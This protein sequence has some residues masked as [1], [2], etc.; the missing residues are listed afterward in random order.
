VGH[1]FYLHLSCGSETHRGDD[2]REIRHLVVVRVHLCHHFVS[3]RAMN[4]DVLN[5]LRYHYC[6]M[7]REMIVLMMLSPYV[8]Y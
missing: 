5:V 4:G 7:M 8:R 2:H 1:D 3:V 6:V